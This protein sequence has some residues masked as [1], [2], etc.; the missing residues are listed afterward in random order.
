MEALELQRQR[1][2]GIL[3]L[4]EC[5]LDLVEESV[6]NTLAEIAVVVIVHF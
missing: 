3:H 1:L 6:D 2:H 4:L 5:A